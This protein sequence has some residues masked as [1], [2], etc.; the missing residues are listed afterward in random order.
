MRDK[1]LAKVYDALLFS[2]MVLGASTAI[3]LAVAIPFMSFSILRSGFC[4]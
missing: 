3:T 1:I 4:N 2:G